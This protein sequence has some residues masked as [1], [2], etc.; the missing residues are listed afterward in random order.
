MKFLA[1]MLFMTILNT[2]LS[3]CPITFTIGFDE[4]FSAD[5]RY[6]FFHYTL[7][8]RPQKKIK[9]EK[10]APAPEKPKESKL[11]SLYKEKGLAGF[12]HFISNLARIASGTAKKIFQHLTVSLMS[13]D[14]SVS[15]GDAAQTAVNYGYVCSAVFPAVSVLLSNTNYKDYTVDIKP[16][17]NS[18][19]ST[20]KFRCK[21]KI[22]V[23]FLMTAAIYALKSF[24]KMKKNE[25]A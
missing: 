15:S 21:A 19:E 7:A 4:E 25:S 10:K 17:F 11:K 22:K 14:I 3:L 1:F 8:P 6:L 5:I 16:D 9:N 23:I 2:F 24:I 18:D 13:V 12:I 20:V